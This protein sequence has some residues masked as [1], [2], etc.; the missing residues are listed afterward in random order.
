M[1]RVNISLADCVGRRDCNARIALEFSRGTRWSEYLAFEPSG[2]KKFREPTDEFLRRFQ[3]VLETPLEQVALRLLRTSRSDYL[4]DDGVLDILLEIYTMTATTTTSADLSGLTLA[5]L[6]V[7][8]NKLSV[9]SG[10]KEVKAFKSKGEA[11][12]RIDVLRAAVVK[13]TEEQVAHKEDAGA[14]ALKRLANVV[15]DKKPAATKRAAKAVEPAAAPT[16]KSAAAAKML[17]DKEAAKAAKAAK[18]TGSAT[19]TRGLGI[20]AFC[21]EAILKGKTNEE[22]LTAVRAKFPSASTSASSI[23]WY[24]N[25]L[26]SEG[27][28]KA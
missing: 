26:K 14:K 15:T 18:K 12:K 20:G 5:E 7:H 23:A 24:R 27:L 28:L 2:L 13:P 22:V 17:A 16:K 25:K 21:S 1:G 6:M 4:P 9:A 8:Y 10:G 3:K 19:P 11:L